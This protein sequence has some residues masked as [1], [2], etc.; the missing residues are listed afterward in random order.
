M[1]LFIHSCTRVYIQPTL[2]EHRYVRLPKALTVGSGC[3]TLAK[4]RAAF[5]E[6]CL[7]VETGPTVGL[8]STLTFH[9]EGRWGRGSQA[10]GIGGV[11]VPSVSCMD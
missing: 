1:H 3:V 10:G 9:A 2:T 5:R 11:L 4:P 8:M 6:P 7:A